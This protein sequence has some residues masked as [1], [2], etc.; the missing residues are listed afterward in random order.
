[1]KQSTIRVV[2]I[3]L[4]ISVTALILIFSLMPASQIEKVVD[5]FLFADFGA[6]LLAYAAFGF[7]FFLAIV[8]LG[9]KIT[10]R[11]RAFEV[12]IVMICGL[13]LGALIEILQPLVQRSC[14]LPDIL[15]DLIGTAL[16]IAVAALL[17]EYI[18]NI[19]ARKQ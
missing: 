19:P 15:A 11:R 18:Q 17:I 13:V 8:K 5:L 14:Q 1:M 12:S 9:Q 16:G 4:L 6:H 7:C 3:I 10:A 2:G